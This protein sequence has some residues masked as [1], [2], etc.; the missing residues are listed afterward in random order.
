ML[1][2]HRPI[3]HKILPGAHQILDGQAHALDLVSAYGLIGAAG[4]GHVA[5][6]NGHRRRRGAATGQAEQKREKNRVFHRD[7]VRYI[8]ALRS[9]E[10]GSFAERK[11]TMD[12]TV[13]L[14]MD[15]CMAH[16]FKFHTLADLEAESGRLGLDLRF[17]DD[18]APLFTPARIGPLRAG[19]SLCV[20][21]MEGCD[22][23]L[24]GG[25]GDLTLRRYQRFGAGGAKIVW[26]EATAVVPEGRATPRQ[27]YISEATL[28]GL[29]RMLDVCRQ[30]HRA[31]LRA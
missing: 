14:S 29:A 22:G 15:P 1:D 13:T 25:P 6:V 28:P 3:T 27:L 21:P 24:E 7:S 23:T 8:V 31:C 17:T 19:N 16:F 4:G 12:G 18:L 30:A 10:G 20:Q 11:A 9:A 26:A 2:I 5:Q